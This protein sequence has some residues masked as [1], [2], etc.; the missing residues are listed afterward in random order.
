M[1]QE[2]KNQLGRNIQLG[3]SVL[4]GALEA[5][6]HGLKGDAALRV[7]LGIKENLGMAYILLR[8][9]LKVSPGEIVEVLF[10]NEHCGPFVVNV[11]EGLEIV[12]L[13]GAPHLLDAL[14]SQG[15]TIALGQGKHKLWLQ[16]AFNVQMQFRLG[17]ACDERFQ[18]VHVC[19]RI[20]GPA[21]MAARP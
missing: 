13:I 14:E 21:E 11:Q 5:R 12:K 16:R 17:N 8:G 10:L 18:A 15:N 3:S 4:H 6:N 19:S 7:G 2:A 20:K 1:A 9:P